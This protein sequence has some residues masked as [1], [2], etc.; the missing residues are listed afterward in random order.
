MTT[1]LNVQGM[2][3]EACVGHVTRALTALTGVES[4]EVSLQNHS[5]VVTYDPAVA[6]VPQMLDAIAEEGYEATLRG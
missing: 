6:Q 5:A 2:S 4:A 1:E 3:C